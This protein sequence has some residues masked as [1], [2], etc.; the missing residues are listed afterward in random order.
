MILVRTVTLS[1]ILLLCADGVPVAV[2]EQGNPTLDRRDPLLRTWTDGTG[3]YKVEAAF[4]EAQDGEIRLRM[5]DGELTLVPLDRLS[6]ADQEYVK[7]KM[8]EGQPSGASTFVG[9]EFT[10]LSD[11]RIPSARVSQA[12]NDVWKLSAEAAEAKIPLVQVSSGTASPEGRAVGALF[13]AVAEE[14]AGKCEAAIG[15]YRQLAADRN[16]TPYGASASFRLPLLDPSIGEDAAFQTLARQPPEDGWYL[17]HVNGWSWGDSRKVALNELL[18]IRSDAVSVRFFEWLRGY[19]PFPSPY[20]YLFILLAI[21]V[22]STVLTFPW[23]IKLARSAGQWRNLAYETERIK[24]MY[25]GSP[26]IYLQEVGQLYRRHGINPAAGC[27]IFIVQVAFAIW[28]LIAMRAYWPRMVLDSSRFL[29]LSDITQFDTR[30]VALT[31]LAG[32]VVPLLTGQA[33]AQ[34]KAAGQPV[35]GMVISGA[36]GFTIIGAIAYH[37]DWPAYVFIFFLLQQI[38][39]TITQLVFGAIGRLTAR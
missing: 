17:T 21:S 7:Q 2:A 31:A 6:A 22:G 13:V 38:L 5:A 27:L 23:H 20:A 24:Q 4:V 34:A 28:V 33:G 26:Q 8:T 3:K 12:L 35:I 1:L 14:R 30:V 9:T 29:W 19:S 39:G 18:R 25:A 15:A 10:W 32:I 11:A 36:V 37:W 16:G